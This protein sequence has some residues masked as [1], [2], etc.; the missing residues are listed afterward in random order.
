MSVSE[1]NTPTSTS[2]SVT[3]NETVSLA[4]DIKKYGKYGTDKLIT[5]RNMEPVVES[6]K[7][8]CCEYILAILHACINIVREF[9]RK[10]ISLN[11]QFEVVVKKN[12]GCVDYAFQAL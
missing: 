11:P 5:L 1:A 6:N 7:A 4:N 3:G 8:I 9:T 12:M 2:T 10:K